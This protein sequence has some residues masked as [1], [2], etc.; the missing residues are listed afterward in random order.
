MTLSSLYRVVAAV[1]TLGVLLATTDVDFPDGDEIELF[2]V[3]I[4]NQAEPP[5]LPMPDPGSSADAGDEDQQQELPTLEAEDDDCLCMPIVQHLVQNLLPE[6][7]P[8]TT[9]PIQ[10]ARSTFHPPPAI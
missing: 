4:S 6:F 5:A 9:L 1:L 2:G 3:P 8:I 7:P 10:S